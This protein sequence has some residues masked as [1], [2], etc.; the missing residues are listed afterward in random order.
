MVEGSGGRGLGFTARAFE[1]W[2][3]VYDSCRV[4]ASGCKVHV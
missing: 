3:R 1:L 2:L 4:Q